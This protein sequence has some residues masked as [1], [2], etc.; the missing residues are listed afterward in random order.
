MASGEGRVASNEDNQNTTL[1][2]SSL[3]THGYS[4]LARYIREVIVH[5]CLRFLQEVALDEVQAHSP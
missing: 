1:R 4:G 2:H 5:L 3:A